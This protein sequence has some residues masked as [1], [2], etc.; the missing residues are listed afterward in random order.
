M[1]VQR[2]ISG[3]HGWRFD[4]IGPLNGGLAYIIQANVFGYDLVALLDFLDNDLDSN[5]TQIR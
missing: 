1:G 5:T 4:F 3:H 2:R